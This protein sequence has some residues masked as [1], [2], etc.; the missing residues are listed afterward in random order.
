[1]AARAIDA[2]H[3]VRRNLAIPVNKQQRERV[4][5]SAGTYSRVRRHAA[6]R[7]SPSLRM[8]R[9]WCILARVSLESE[10]DGSADDAGASETLRCVLK[11]VPYLVSSGLPASKTP[12]Y[13]NSGAEANDR[14]AAASDGAAAYMHGGVR[15]GLVDQWRKLLIADRSDPLQC[16][17]LLDRNMEHSRIIRFPKAHE[18]RLRSM[19]QA[20]ALGVSAAP[21][22]SGHET[23]LQQGAQSH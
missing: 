6:R 20:C 17:H 1:M 8:L 23:L 3:E 5:A 2:R 7:L 19:R 13:L 10:D 12:W 21:R 15:R 14:R 9:L 22:P 11:V 18:R 16:L 4:T